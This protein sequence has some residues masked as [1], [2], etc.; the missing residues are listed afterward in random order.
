MKTV[1]PRWVC[2]AFLLFGLA[3]LTFGTMTLTEGDTGA[4]VVK[5]A[6][7]IGWLLVAAFKGI[8]PAVQGGQRSGTQ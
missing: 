5:L 4:G 2:I 8:R 7:G 6:L 3:W 1:T